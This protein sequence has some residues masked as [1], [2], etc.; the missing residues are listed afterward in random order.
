LSGGDVVPVLSREKL[1]ALIERPAEIGISIYMPSHRVVDTKQDQIR[2]K[3]LLREGEKKLIDSGV[4]ATEARQLLE[5]VEK[6][7]ASDFFWQHQSE[8]LAIFSSLSNF[9][10]FRLPYSPKE[11]VV[12]AERFHTKPLISLLSGDG[13]FYVLALSQNE[14]RL[15]Q[16]SR[17]NA[18]VITPERVPASL[19]EVLKYDEFE[20]QLQF[21]TGTGTGPGK[22]A[23]IFHGQGVGIDNVKDNIL[24]YFREIDRG[25]HELF[26]E[27]QAPLV[28]AGVDYLHAIY[29]QANNYPHLLQEGVQGNVDGMSAKELQQRAWKVVRPYFERGQLEAL[30]R[31]GEAAGKGLTAEDVKQV[32]LAAYDGRVDTLFVAVG[33]QNW[34]VFDIQRRQV[35]LYEKA[36][37]G[38]QDLL[39]LAAALTLTRSGTVY[40]IESEKVPSKTS[41]A[42]IL[43]Y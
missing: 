12:V 5:P 26:R 6:L 18:W 37:K 1:R 34:G 41:I 20:K 10:Y 43:R 2:L 16:C 32:V 31:Y 15:L 25:L 7:S 27:E 39:D 28:L 13:I 23:A 29:R 24:R 36:E 8:G 19:A 9:C 42:A 35:N 33:V 22:R 4:R 40:A 21:H 30:K 17:D 14:V 38:A 3:N 11:L